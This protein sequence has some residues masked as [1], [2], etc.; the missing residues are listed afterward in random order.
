MTT[1]E[2]LELRLNNKQAI[3]AAKE[4]EQRM[5]GHMNKAAS[6]T[7][8]AGRR[9]EEQFAKKMESRLGKAAI[10]FGAVTYATRQLADALDKHF[11][12]IS[13]DAPKLEDFNSNIHKSSEA[14]VA[15]KQALNDPELEGGF[16]KMIGFFVT[17]ADGSVGRANEFNQMLASMKKRQQDSDIAM[18]MGRDEVEQFG[19]GTTNQLLASGFATKKAAIDEKL[20]AKR[21]AAREKELKETI[22]F[23]DEYEKI[24]MDFL[25]KREAVDQ[26]NADLRLKTQNDFQTKYAAM[27]D[28]FEEYDNEINARITKNNKEALEERERDMKDHAR[29][30]ETINQ[31][32]F[33]NASSIFQNMASVALDSLFAIAEGQKISGKEVAYQFLKSQG[34]MLFGKGL[35]DF[36]QGLAYTFVPGFQAT[37]AA[38]MTVGKMEMGAGTVMMAGA[39]PM[40]KAAGGGGGGGGGGGRDGAAGGAGWL[41]TSSRRSQDD[42]PKPETIV[43]N[44]N[45]VL[46]SKEAGLDIVEAIN[47]AQRKG[48]LT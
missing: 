45:G 33:D 15:L 2:E 36:L 31:A 27:L 46:T 34:Q 41:E 3:A 20:A 6:N 48:L 19:G 30:Q 43:I 26:E 47:R 9:M 12:L 5:T 18:D 23:V 11:R 44:V 37:G 40:A 22:E 42:G 39:L 14:M 10:A 28:S 32:M 13:K 38:L 21:K 24:T 16:Q 35:S 8:A 17:M 1:T 7:E 4:F 29:A 25:R